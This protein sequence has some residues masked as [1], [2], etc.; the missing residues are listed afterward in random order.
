MR[1]AG[2]AAFRRRLAKVG[3]TQRELSKDLKKSLKGHMDIQ[4][5]C[6]PGR[7]AASVMALRPRPLDKSCSRNNTELT[8][9]P[10]DWPKERELGNIV[11]VTAACPM[12]C[13]YRGCYMV[14][15]FYSK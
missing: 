2:W 4:K 5:N 8:L 15:G 10:P 11:I 3:H 7:T 1:R 6:I 12:M 14:L 9:S 13:V